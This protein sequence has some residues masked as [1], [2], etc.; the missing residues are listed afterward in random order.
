MTSD[1]ISSAPPITT[2]TAPALPQLSAKA[3][4]A[5][6]LVLAA[7]VYGYG[8][9]YLSVADNPQRVGDFF[10]D[11]A[12]AKN[13]FTGLPIYTSQEETALR[14]LNYRH[15]PS[16]GVFV[17]VNGHPPASVITALPLAQLEYAEAFRL[18]RSEERRVGKECRSRWSP[19]H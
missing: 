10:Q 5:W 14:Y 13:F 4:A 18:W 3:T 12:S 15:D 7:T 6:C 2:P 17:R 1:S 11:W 19:Y 16:R 8:R 9:A